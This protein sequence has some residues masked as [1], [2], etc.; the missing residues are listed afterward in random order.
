MQIGCHVSISGGL[1]KSIDRAVERGAN[2]LQS[3]A[4]SPR[5][6][7]TT[8]FDDHV[9]DQYRI[10]KKESGIGEHYFHAPYLINLA[11]ENKSY[12]TAS[13]ETL[14]FYQQFSGGIH[15]SGTIVHVGSHKGR[16]FESVQPAV[17]RAIVEVLEQTPSGVRLLLENAA[18]QKGVIGDSFDELEVLIASVPKKLQLKIG[19]CLDSQHAFAS[20]HDVRTKEGVDRM[21]SVFDNVIGLE[22]LHVIHA[23]DSKIEF[24]SHRDRH[25]NIGSGFIGK[26]GFRHLVNHPK[27]KHLPFILEVPGENRSG[28]RKIDVEGLKQLVE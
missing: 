5:S 21:L 16:G 7:K 3:F 23:N 11:H 1:D 20:G 2:C 22:F 6:L 19:I 17:S 25:E 28:P 9:V 8:S 13:V 12:V 15:G 27:L 10:K 14:I 18:G 4:S 26:E 24:N